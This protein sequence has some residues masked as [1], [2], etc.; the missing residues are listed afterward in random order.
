MT[1][2]ADQPI[3]TTDSRPAE[4]RAPQGGTYVTTH[5]RPTTV[6]SYVTTEGLA[7]VPAEAIRGRYVSLGYVPAEQ[8]E[9]RYTGRA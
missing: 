3:Q 4:N 9:G 8:S 5:S 6:G 7:T 2:L 1:L